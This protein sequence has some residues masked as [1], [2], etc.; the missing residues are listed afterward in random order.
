M[1]ETIYIFTHLDKWWKIVA[2]QILLALTL[3][4]L[5]CIFLFIFF[6]SWYPHII[7]RCF[8]YFQNINGPFRLC[9]KINKWLNV[10]IYLYACVY[11]IGNTRGDA[12]SVDIRH[13]RGKKI[14][15][16]GQSLSHVAS[17]LYIYLCIYICELFMVLKCWKK[18]GRSSTWN[19]SS[20]G[21]IVGKLFFVL[22][23][24]I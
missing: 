3:K 5:L 4:F 2:W 16:K 13:K 14:K 12:S 1:G 6:S 7:S 11:V 23:Y 15:Y 8:C 22:K 9:P 19:R 21:R 18:L 24:I 17:L 20:P 10:Y